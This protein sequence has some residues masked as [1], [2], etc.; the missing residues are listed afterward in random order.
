MFRFYSTRYIC[1]R[2]MDKIARFEPM[3]V[4]L[5][6]W[7]GFSVNMRYGY[8]DKINVLVILCFQADLVCCVKSTV[9][10]LATTQRHV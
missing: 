5:C 10:W 4:M 3:L 7:I 2:I 1:L 9:I 6:K 8:F